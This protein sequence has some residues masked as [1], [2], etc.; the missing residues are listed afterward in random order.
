MNFKYNISLFVL[1]IL[2]CGCQKYENRDIES[3]LKK[4]EINTS[5]VLDTI[6]KRNWDKVYIMTPYLGNKKLSS[7]EMPS[8]VRKTLDQ[9]SMSDNINTLVF[10]QKN[11]IISFATIRRN[12]ADFDGHENQIYGRTQVF[13]VVEYRNIISLN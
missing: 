8:E 3:S 10:T 5:F 9:N 11:K 12:I 6:E 4:L 1:I 13:K 2:L 7:V